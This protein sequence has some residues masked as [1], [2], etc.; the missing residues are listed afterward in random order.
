MVQTWS[1]QWL[2]FFNDVKLLIDVAV[3]VIKAFVS[4]K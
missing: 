1:P 3:A 2:T 4:L